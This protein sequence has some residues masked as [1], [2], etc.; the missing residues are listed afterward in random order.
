ML[1]PPVEAA[2]DL[3]IGRSL[4]AL[5]FERTVQTGDALEDEQPEGQHHAAEG[6]PEPDR[7]VHLKDLTDAEGR[8][9]SRRAAC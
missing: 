4:A 6:R 3:P 9:Q 1:R 2:D 8:V 7:L 5:V